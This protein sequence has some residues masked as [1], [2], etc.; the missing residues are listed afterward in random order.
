MCCS[1][2]SRSPLSLLHVTQMF[3]FCLRGTTPGSK[4]SLL[5]GA[6]R[7]S[8][9]GTLVSTY[10]R[11]CH[12]S[13][14]PKGRSADSPASLLLGPHRSV[15]SAGER[16]ASV[17]TQSPGSWVP[18]SEAPAVKGGASLSVLAAVLGGASSAG[19]A[20]GRSPACSSVRRKAPWSCGAAIAA[21]DTCDAFA[22]VSCGSRWMNE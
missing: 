17:P 7:E 12:P 1:G 10:H 3:G 15:D 21:H 18:S 20:S 5:K 14:P 11:A 8:W 22:P 13:R 9:G 19:E 16:S 2:R 6:E 4:T